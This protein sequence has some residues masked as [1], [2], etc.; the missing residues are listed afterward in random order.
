MTR[1]LI[2]AISAF[3]LFSVSAF[4]QWGRGD[5]AAATVS[6][7]NR[8][9]AAEGTRIFGIVRAIKDFGHWDNT[10]IIPMAADLNAGE[11]STLYTLGGATS[12]NLT[13]LNSPTWGT[14]GISFNGSN[15]YATMPKVFSGG[16]NL[17]LFATY[18]SSEQTGVIASEWNTSGNQRSWIYF[19]YTTAFAGN[20]RAFGF[21]TDGTTGTNSFFSMS[22]TI[23]GVSTRQV[24]R[25]ASNTHTAFSN[26]STQAVVSASG[27]GTGNMHN[28]STVFVIG[29]S[30][31]GSSNLF[32]GTISSLIA[33][34]AGLTYEQTLTVDGLLYELLAPYLP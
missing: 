29:G 4:P 26:G 2:L 23:T 6:F 17:T 21:S 11:G 7:V 33:S 8:S 18:N 30:N 1:I 5:A 34:G 13:L 27:S 22:P 28:H 10:V 20:P 12:N 3:Q 24:V 32:S 14:A 16:A 31:S 9:G 19:P 15:Q 25:K